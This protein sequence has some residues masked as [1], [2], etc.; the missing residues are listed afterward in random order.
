MADYLAK[1]VGVKLHHEM[2]YQIIYQ[3]K[4]QARDLYQY[5]RVASKP[6]RKRYDRRGKIKNRTC[7]EERPLIVDEF[8]CIGGLNAPV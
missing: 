1:Y 8:S 5:L 2:I 6:Y 4:A 3:D 7:I